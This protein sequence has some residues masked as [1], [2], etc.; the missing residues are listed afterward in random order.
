MQTYSEYIK[1]IIETEPLESIP[2]LLEHLWKSY[3]VYKPVGKGILE[4]KLA[5]ADS[6]THTLSRKRRIRLRNIMATLC[7][8][9]EQEAFVTGIRVGALL[10]TE[11][12]QTP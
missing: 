2:S 10:M 11:L 5:Q 6:I 1:A 3:T 12:T 4:E 8:E 9:Y 7:A